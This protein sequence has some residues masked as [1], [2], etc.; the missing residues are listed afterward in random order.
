MPNPVVVAG[1]ICDY[2]LMVWMRFCDRLRVRHTPTASAVIAALL[3]VSGCTAP[4]PEVVTHQLHLPLSGPCPTDAAVLSRGEFGDEVQSFVATVAGPGISGALTGEAPAAVTIENV[5][6]GEDRIFALFG[7]VSGQARWR[8]ISAPTAIVAG[9]APT[10]DV[11]MAAVADVSC[12]RSPAGARAFH[13]ATA[14]LNG[15]ILIVGGAGTVQDAT[16]TCQSACLRATATASATIYDPKTG[17]FSEVG[18][19]IGPRMFHTAA[20][21]PD[22]RVVIAGGTGEAFLRGVDAARFPFPIE[23]TRPLN[24]VEVYDPATRSFSAAGADPAGARVFGA[25]ITTLNGEVLITGG[26]PGPAQAGPNN[27]SNALSSTTVCS[28]GSLSCVAG[29]PMARARAGHMMFTIDPEGVFVWGGSVD[30][31]GEGF[32]M[33]HLP[34]NAASFG[35][36]SVAGMQPTRNVFFATGTRYLDFRFLAAGGLFRRADGTFSAVDD[37]NNNL[38][39]RAYVF[40][41]TSGA[42]GGLTPPMAMQSGRMFASAAPLP[43]Q[44][45]A[46]VVGGFAVPANLNSLDWTA[47]A[48]LELFD[49]ASLQMLAITVNGEARTLREPRAGL[50]ATAIGDGTVVF[51]GGYSDN[52]A[53]ETAEVFA[54]IKTPPQAAG[55]Q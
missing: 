46:V 4:S 10:V 37:D 25:A 13:T 14:L 35:L 23:P 53:S 50:T 27:L 2:I 20:A 12:A 3:A 9:E 32:Q 6:P 5:P 40:D 29:P 7:L 31:A 34:A 21:L 44:A 43:D 16:A 26:I 19:L 49:E 1:R 24:T 47:S 30:T 15:T 18:S 38:A 11:V 51:V 52:R 36:L 33:E 48:D 8:G 28:G 22:G 17:A 55:F 41:I 45:S 42:N 54:D 39:A